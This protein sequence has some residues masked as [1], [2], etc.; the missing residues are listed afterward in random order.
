[1]TDRVR[2]VEP[3]DGAWAVVVDWDGDGDWEAADD[4]LATR[5]EAEALATVI[6]RELLG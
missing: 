6:R 2:V 5:S 4:W 3:R 1:M